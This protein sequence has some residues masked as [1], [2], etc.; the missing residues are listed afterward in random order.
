MKIKDCSLQAVHGVFI[1]CGLLWHHIDKEQETSHCSGGWEGHDRGVHILKGSCVSSHGRQWKDKEWQGAKLVFSKAHSLH[2]PLPP[3]P[4]P[5]ISAVR[6]SWGTNPPASLPSL[7]GPH[8]QHH[9][10]GRG[11]GWEG[12]QHMK[13]GTPFKSKQTDSKLIWGMEFWM[14]LSMPPW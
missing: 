1:L 2:N 10:W 13:T 3:Q 11:F 9:W 5:S 6:A 12:F 7:T 8:S 14:A 4:P